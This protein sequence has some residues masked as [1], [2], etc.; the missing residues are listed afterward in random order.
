MTLTAA[1]LHALRDEYTRTIKP[2]RALAAETLILERP[3]GD[4][5]DQA[6]VPTSAEI[7]RCSHPVVFADDGAAA[8][9]EA[10]TPVLGRLDLLQAVQLPDVF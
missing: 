10:W 9:G 3:L 6:Y 1:G 8:A 5:T 7:V 4:L 2:A